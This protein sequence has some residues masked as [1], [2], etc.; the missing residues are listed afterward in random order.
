[1]WINLIEA[2]MQLALGIF[3]SLGFYIMPLALLSLIWGKLSK[4]EPWDEEDV[5]LGLIIFIW[6]IISWYLIKSGFVNSYLRY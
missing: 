3:V 1:V 2:L 4:R 5:K 6:S